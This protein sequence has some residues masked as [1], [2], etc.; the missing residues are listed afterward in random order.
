VSGTA[1][2][3]SLVVLSAIV[4]GR[5]DLLDK[6]LRKLLPEHFPDPSHRA[7]FQLLERY[8][9]VTGTVMPRAA[10]ADILRSNTDASRVMVYEELY[11][12]LAQAQVQE[13]DFTWSLDML[14]DLE[15]E[16][17]TA[18]ALTEG[19]EVLRTG[20]KA[21]RGEFRK[22]HQ[23]ART[24]V[25]ER[26]AELDRALSMQDSPEGDMR[27]ESLEM[28]KD[29]SDRRELHLSGRAKGVLFG[30]Q[31]LDDKINGFQPGELNLIAGY[32]SDGKTALCV[33]LSW[34]AC[35]EQGLNVAFMTTETLRPQVRRKVLAR[36]SMLPQFGLPDGLNTRDL[37][38]GTLSAE[39]QQKLQDEVVP[40]FTRNPAYGRLQIVQV[41]RGATIATLEAKL[42]RIQRSFRVDLVVM[43][44]LR[45][46]QPDGRRQSDRESLGAIVVEAKQLAT[47]FDNGRGVPFVSPWQVNR[48]ARDEAERAGFYT[49]K[50]LA[51]TAETTNTSDVI[52]S[53]LAPSDNE[54]RKCEVKLQILKNRDGEKSNGM[55]VRVDYATA[56][57]TSVSR[58]GG[59]EQL[60]GDDSDDESF[61][62]LLS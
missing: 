44:Y 59:M 8:S 19:M 33:Q 43:D 50:A 52:V 12:T 15:A 61:A 62:G 17:A 9:E 39:E 41:P 4:P 37:K 55:T 20:A 24:V 28:L 11:D 48:S 35:V 31:E 40:D 6:A 14:R 21:P 18:A 56:C 60:L 2:D 54:N 58:E 22:G 45:L 16:R 5:Q 36:H 34:A 53:L 3:H 26:F 42:Y 1:H 32:S 38:N 49:S 30:I 7:M 27:K 13:S 51:E 10:L 47:T 57:F 25:L 46:L 23:D 29:Y